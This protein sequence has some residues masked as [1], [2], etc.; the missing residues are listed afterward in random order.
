MLDSTTA[1]LGKDAAVSVFMTLFNVIE[2]CMSNFNLQKVT[3]F[4]Q[5]TLH[6][7][8]IAYMVFILL[9]HY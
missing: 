5:E 6:S 9:L 8:S 7:P 4:L 3:Y 1:N 2:L